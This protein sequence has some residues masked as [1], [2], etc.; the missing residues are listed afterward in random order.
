MSNNQRE[1]LEDR[2]AKRRNVRNKRYLGKNSVDESE[3]T[4]IN[5]SPTTQSLDRKSSKRISH[6][7]SSNEQRKS[8]S[9]I[10][11]NSELP[12]IENSNP[13]QNY[14]LSENK[15]S[16]T[17][18][19]PQVAKH[20]SLE[21]E[22]KKQELPNEQQRKYSPADEKPTIIKER[23]LPPKKSD[24]VQ[25]ETHE[26]P[27]NIKE[28]VLPP[29]KSDP[30]QQE[31]REKPV[32]IKETIKPVNT[33]EK[34]K[35]ISH[36]FR[37]NSLPNRIQNLSSSPEFDHPLTH[38]Q[39]KSD[40]KEKI[41][42]FPPSYPKPIART[43]SEQ[44]ISTSKRKHQSNDSPFSKQNSLALSYLFNKRMINAE[45]SH[46]KSLDDPQSKLKTVWD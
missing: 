11:K 32:I 25:Q 29:Q 23:V 24:P 30:I 39:L 6:I 17:P 22:N 33:I 21:L 35:T 18:I 43:S 1:S 19:L 16:S 42:N 9:T 31:T 20:Q 40:P 15:T 7:N 12:P 5:H 13:K 4:L 10:M 27:M 28:K 26:K 37:E 36:D 41:F 45:L 44:V 2:L 8:S 3:I 46:T 38:P 14:F 34:L